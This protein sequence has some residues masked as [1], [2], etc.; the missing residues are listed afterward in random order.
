MLKK[1]SPKDLSDLFKHPQF[2]SIFDVRDDDYGERGIIKG[3]NHLPYRSITEDTIIKLVS[4]KLSSTNVFYCTFGRARSPNVVSKM[5]KM[6]PEMNCY[7][8]EG[9][10]RSIILS[11]EYHYMLN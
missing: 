1:I 8:L 11:P 3:S 6:Y 4:N 5:I 7:Y 9:G 2:L 10:I